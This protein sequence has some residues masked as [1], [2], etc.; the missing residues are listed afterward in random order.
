MLLYDRLLKNR[1]ALRH[2]T[3]GLTLTATLAGCH[4]PQIKMPKWP[5]QPY[6][7]TTRTPT[8][9]APPVIS[10]PIPEASLPP[11]MEEY[12]TGGPALAPAPS[13]PPAEEPDGRQ[14]NAP[15]PNEAPT[16]LPP[17]KSNAPL[18]APKKAQAPRPLGSST[19]TRLQNKER[20]RPTEEIPDSDDYL[21]PDDVSA[22]A[23]RSVAP[24][25][26]SVT[27][28]KKE[29]PWR[30]QSEVK[31]PEIPP[32]RLKKSGTP[33]PAPKEESLPT[34][35]A[36][37]PIKKRKADDETSV[38]QGHTPAPEIDVESTVSEGPSL[39]PS[40]SP[41]PSQGLEQK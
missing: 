23:S 27:L 40:P 5:W 41:Y 35:S 18:K 31:L 28:P 26:R 30:S 32:H 10:E 39:I 13:A 11:I 16:P 20:K 3:L 34:L 36:P 17:P 19:A 8:T 12:P 9:L 33:Q 37:E 21:S 24:Q 14:E 38:P 1:R 22:S 15:A 7:P 6:T 4:C 2:L 25:S 29:D